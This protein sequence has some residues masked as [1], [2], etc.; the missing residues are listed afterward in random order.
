[1]RY[2]ENGPMDEHPKRLQGLNKRGIWEYDLGDFESYTTDNGVTYTRADYEAY[3][4]LRAPK[5]RLNV[6]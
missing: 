3:Y 5:T 4:K 1:M 6:E 2:D